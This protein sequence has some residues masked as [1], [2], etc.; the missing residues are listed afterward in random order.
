MLPD[1]K[2]L[3]DLMANPAVEKVFHGGENDVAL[4]KRDFGFTLSGVYDTQIAARFCGRTQLGLQALLGS[5]LRVTHFKDLQRCDWSRRPL[6]P[7]QEA[8]A[9]EDVRHLFTLRDRLNAELVT[10]GRHEWAREECDDLAATPPVSRRE[11]GE[12]FRLRGAAD[13]SP[14]ELAALRELFNLRDEWARRAD[15]PPFKIANDEVLVEL[16]IRRPRDPRALRHMRGLSA[17]LRERCAPDL[18]A[19]VAR[20]EALPEGALPALPAAVRNRRSPAVRMRIDRLK[21]WR[22]GAAAQAG[23][24]PG[25]LLPQRLIEAIAQG[26]PATPEALAAVPGV[27]RWRVASFGGGILESMRG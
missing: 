24:D 25:L 5:E 11:P 20:A 7:A 9:A 21:A 13:L 10:R 14:R 26:G 12:F 16:A 27:R 17:R 23:L 15:L 19:A 4:L 8:Y 6:T 22:A 18:V 3:G 1:L 2:A